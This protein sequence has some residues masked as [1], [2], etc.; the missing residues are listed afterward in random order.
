MGQLWLLLLRGLLGGALVVAFAVIAE[1]VKPKLFSGLFS[2]APS[3]AIA[4]LLVT[5][6]ATKPEQAGQAAL[7]PL[8]LAEE[9][10]ARCGQVTTTGRPASGDDGAKA[11]SGLGFS[12]R[13]SI[14]RTILDFL[15]VAP[16][17]GATDFA[18]AQ[19]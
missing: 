7:G 1:V 17:D 11:R 3:I 19:A 13:F 16:E 15:G 14:K 2:A 10:A 6:Y 12:A 9:M 5:A 4:G 8:H 18:R